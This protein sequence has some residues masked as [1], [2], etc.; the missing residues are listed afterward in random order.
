MRSVN[1]AT[2]N[3]D[4]RFVVCEKEFTPNLEKGGVAFGEAT[5]PK[6]FLLIEVHK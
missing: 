4:K 6:G 1:E 2:P 5:P 3:L